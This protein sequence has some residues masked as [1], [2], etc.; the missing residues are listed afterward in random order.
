MVAA[1]T[2]AMTDRRLGLRL[3]ARS[4][5]RC[6]SDRRID[7]SGGDCNT[8]EP[9]FAMRGRSYSPRVAVTRE[10]GM[11]P[12][13]TRSGRWGG[14]PAGMGHEERFLPSTE[15]NGRSGSTAVDF[16]VECKWL[17]RVES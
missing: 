9:H 15:A 1:P 5:S 13:C 10:W 17:G 4:L 6:I 2:A 7:W 12:W 11:L 14:A 3:I 16:T 8:R